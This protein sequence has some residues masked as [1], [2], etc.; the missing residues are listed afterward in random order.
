MLAVMGQ[1]HNT[2][3]YI[4]DSDDSE[5]LLIASNNTSNEFTTTF[6]ESRGAGGKVYFTNIPVWMGELRESALSP[7]SEQLLMDMKSRQWGMVTSM[8]SFK[9]ERY[10]DS[11]DTVIGE[12]RLMDDTD[13]TNSMISLAF[14]WS[15]KQEDGTLIHVASGK[16]LTT[17]VSIEQHGVVKKAP[18]PAYLN[19]YLAQLP[20]IFIENIQWLN[21][22]KQ[23]T[24]K[25]VSV[26]APDITKRKKYFLE[27]QEFL[28]STEDSNLVG[29][30]Y[31]S[32]YYSWQARLRDHYLFAYFPEI[33]Q[34]SNKSEFV[35]IYAEVNHL[36]EAMPFEIIEVSM[37]LYELFAEGFTLYFEYYSVSEHGTRRRKLA[38]GEHSV[39]W[40]PEGQELSSE[41][42]PAKMPEAYV[43]NFMAIIDKAE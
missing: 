1:L 26:L 18:L 7:I 29:N 32:Q 33:F 17:W 3:K 23:I 38:H 6:V 36:Q 15:K 22:K 27:Q 10:L 34:W 19:E 8:S 31:F 30:I 35:C 14:N 21:E 11:Y 20:P 28:T 37:Y 25:M 5:A 39:V 9:I 4:D 43:A 13:L 16:L 2:Q 42:H 41:I 24:S 12:V 40:V